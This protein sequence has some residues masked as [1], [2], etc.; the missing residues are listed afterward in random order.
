MP[1]DAPE[2][3]KNSL[4]TM[5]GA[6]SKGADLHCTAFSFQRV[7][8]SATVATLDQRMQS[9]DRGLAASTGTNKF[10]RMR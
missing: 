5:D 4:K 1:K 7:G 8:R 3:H 2:E 10:Y 6:G 9:L